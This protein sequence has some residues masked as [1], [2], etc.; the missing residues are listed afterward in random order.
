MKKIRFINKILCI[1]LSICMVFYSF[2]DSTLKIVKAESIYED[3]N[4]GE[5]YEDEDYEDEDYEDYDDDVYVFCNISNMTLFV[6][7]EKT[8]SVDIDDIYD[9]DNELIWWS[10]NSSIASI[11]D[12]GNV[13]GLKEG[14]V[15]ITVQY[16][17]ST[18]KC[19]IVV[20]KKTPTYKQAVKKLKKLSKNNKN[21]IFENIDVGNICRLHAKKKVSDVVDNKVRSQGFMSGLVCFE[22]IEIKK[23]GAGS[24]AKLIIDG[25]MIQIDYFDSVDLSASELKLVSSNRRLSFE[26]YE[27]SSKSSVL[28]RYYRGKSHAKAT[29][30]SSLD[31]KNT[32]LKKYNKMLG[33]KTLCIKFQCVDGAYC[34]IKSNKKMRKNWKSLTKVYS[35]LLNIY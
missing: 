4:E 35:K 1:M 29:I 11:D 10:S 5:D 26:L 2:W 31:K 23:K 14:K 18:D 9:T 3:D 12:N 34:Q 6:G 21:L 30:V 32:I 15:T 17:N 33:Q 20:K 28:R 24:T 16:G 19:N 7:Q 8:I 25:T 13:T 27:I 22:Y